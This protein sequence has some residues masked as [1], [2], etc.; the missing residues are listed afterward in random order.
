MNMLGYIDE[1][2]PMQGERLNKL[3]EA[4]FRKFSA[5]MVSGAIES[6]VPRSELPEFAIQPSAGSRR[7]QQYVTANGQ[8]ISNEGEQ[9]VEALT[10]E[11]LKVKMKY[12]VADVT[13]A[14]CSVGQVCDQGNVLVFTEGGGWIHNRATKNN[15][16]F[17]REGKMYVLNTWVRQPAPAAG[18]TRP[19][20]GRGTRRLT[21]W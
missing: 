3:N 19:F 21:A 15:T 16:H 18:S 11:H 6:V 8:K 9:L 12:Q 17:E 7:G 2:A 4:E 5:Y 1:C 14:L 10:D 13:K 20:E